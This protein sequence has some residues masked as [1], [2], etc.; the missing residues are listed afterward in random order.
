MMVLCLECGSFHHGEYGSGKF[1]NATC[2]RKYSNSFVTK[3]GRESQIKALNDPNNREKIKNT[4][5][6]KSK[7]NKKKRDKELTELFKYDLNNKEDLS[8]LQYESI[9][10]SNIDKIFKHRPHELGK[11]GEN[12]IINQCLAHGIPAYVPVVDTDG[13]DLII[14]INGDLKKIQVKTSTRQ[15]GVNKDKIIFY[16]RSSNIRKDTDTQ[17]YHSNHKTYDDKVDLFA[18]Y[19]AIHNKSYLIENDPSKSSITISQNKTNLNHYDM[20]ATFADECDFGYVIELMKNGISPNSI[21]DG[22]FKELE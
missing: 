15:A 8:I 3:S 14:D 20:N 21:I 18:L 1:C 9:L 6:K 12:V 11:F 22:D 7:K 17:E 13:V 4:R 19:D 10:K 5:K 16:F 2:A